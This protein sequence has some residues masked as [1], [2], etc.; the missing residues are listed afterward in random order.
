MSTFHNLLVACEYSW[1]FLLCYCN[2]L[3]CF[4]NGIIKYWEDLLLHRFIPKG[5]C[6]SILLIWSQEMFSKSKGKVKW[7]SDLAA[8]H[9]ITSQWLK[10]FP[11]RPIEKLR[12]SPNMK[13]QIGMVRQNLKFSKA[14]TFLFYFSKANAEKLVLILFVYL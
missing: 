13:R 9:I 1:F 5:K 10:S 12:Y 4:E 8:S 3:A 11:Y 2:L 6:L 14:S 7:K